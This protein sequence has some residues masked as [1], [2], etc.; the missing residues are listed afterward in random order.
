MIVVKSL[1]SNAFTAFQ[2]DINWRIG[3]SHKTHEQVVIKHCGYVA[4]AE[5]ESEA[6]DQ[7]Y[8]ILS[9]LRAVPS[10]SQP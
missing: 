6:I 5:T 1:N 10:Q 8:E 4:D 9:E 2:P 7:L 3:V